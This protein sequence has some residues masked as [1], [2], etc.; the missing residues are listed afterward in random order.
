MYIR[1]ITN[2]WDGNTATWQTQ[3]ATT[4]TDQLL[5]PH[6]NQG[7]LDLTDLDVKVLIDAMRTSGNYGFMMILQ[8]ETIYTIRQFCSSHHSN[9]AKHPKL[10]IVYQ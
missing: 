7:F 4:T 5:I 2:S 9:T 6:T 3:P 1:R 10:V 8:N